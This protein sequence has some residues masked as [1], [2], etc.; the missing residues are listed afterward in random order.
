MVK[1]GL[2]GGTG[3]DD[4]DLLENRQEKEVDTP[5]GKPSDKLI[6]GTIKNVECVLLARHG[7]KHNINPSNVNYQANMYAFWKEG[8]THV[9]VTTACGSLKEEMAPG[10]MVFLDQF[11]DRTTKRPLTMFD[12]GENS[13]KGVCHIPMGTPFCNHLRELLIDCAKELKIPHHSKGTTVTVEG[14]RF[15]TKAESFLFQSWNCD[16]VNMTTVPEVTLAKELGMSYASIALVTDYDCWK[17]NEEVS[18]DSVM[19]Q[20]KENAK[21]ATKI[22]LHAI[23]QV[24]AKDWNDIIKGNQDLAKSSTM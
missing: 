14:P 8:C 2:I 20:M 12:G 4:P 24:A 21:R 16:I 11:I 13:L 3:L 9:I 22:L 6:T 5:Y 23:P 1:I 18:V 7:R 17:E 15:S 10:H 19:L